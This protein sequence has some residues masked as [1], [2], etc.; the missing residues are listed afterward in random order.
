M[1][2]A[3]WCVQAIEVMDRPRPVVKYQMGIK[4]IHK[5]LFPS[6]PHVELPSM[7]SE[8]SCLDS[9]LLSRDV[10]LPPTLDAPNGTISVFRTR[11]FFCLGSGAETGQQMIALAFR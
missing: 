7:D 2:G 10:E 11:F 8:A 3:L 6:L 5:I 1:A 4:H 9:V